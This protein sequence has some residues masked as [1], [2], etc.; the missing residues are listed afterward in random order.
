MWW[1]TPVGRFPAI[2]TAIFGRLFRRRLARKRHGRVLGI[3]G[4][5]VFQSVN[6]LRREAFVSQIA[7]PHPAASRG[8]GPSVFR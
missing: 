5:F 6:E 7:S 8:A 3:A 4:R 2:T 1:F